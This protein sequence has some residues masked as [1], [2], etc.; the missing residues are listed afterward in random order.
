VYEDFELRRV[1]IAGVEMSVR[2]GGSGPPVLLL[3]G[4]PQT[5]VMW[6]R[7]APELAREH[8]VVA[9]D[10]RG[11]GDSDRPPAGDEDEGYSKRT[12]AA[13]QVALMERLG[14]DRFDAVGHDR[15]ARVVHRMCLDRPEVVRRAAVLDIAPTRHMFETADLEFGLAYYH[16]FF[17]A[18]PPDLPERLIGADPDYWVRH[19]LRAWSRVPDAFDESAV[20]QYV[21]CFSD[22]AAIAAS[23]ADYRAAAGI[24]LRHDYADF[25]AGRRVQGPL[26]VVWGRLGFVGQHYDVPEIWRRY[27][28]DVRA[29][30]LD[31]GHFMAEEA[32]EQTTENLVEFLR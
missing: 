31:C 17:L 32:P 12:M 30:G 5:S 24:D 4:Y 3:H 21:R 8:T 27:A 2:M 19:H 13:E 26:L 23:C 18:Q 7:V 15:G 16:W 9:A 6:H 14:F 1:D 11:Y 28:D 22:P 20:D 10:L 25:A 29:C